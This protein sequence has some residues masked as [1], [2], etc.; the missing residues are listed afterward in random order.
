MKTWEPIETAPE[1]RWILTFDPWAQE[2]EGM[3]VS[4]Y[5]IHRRYKESVVSERERR[6]DPSVSVRKIER[7]EIIERQ[8]EGD[9]CDPSHWMELPDPPKDLDDEVNT[10]RNR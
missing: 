9:A 2:Y 8:W 4:R 5:R 10:W 3:G 6:G 1:G 7:R